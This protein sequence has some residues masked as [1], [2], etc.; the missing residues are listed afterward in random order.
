MNLR[1]GFKIAEKIIDVFICNVFFSQH[2]ITC[3]FSNGMC[4]VAIKNLIMPLHQT[5]IRRLLPLLHSHA[6]LVSLFFGSMYICKWLFWRMKYKKSKILSKMSTEYLENSLR[7]AN[8]AVD[9][10]RCVGFTKTISRIPL[11]LWF[12]CSHFYVLM[13]NHKH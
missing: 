8:T 12:S 4:W 1:V 6:L 10:Y 5:C 7:I 13:K 11:V 2:H 9:P 3:D